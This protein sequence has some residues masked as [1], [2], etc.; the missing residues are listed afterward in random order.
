MVVLP[1]RPAAGGRHAPYDQIDNIARNSWNGQQHRREL[2]GTADA[3]A[4][5][6]HQPVRAN[7]R[8]EVAAQRGRALF[9]QA[10]GAV[11]DCHAGHLRH[12]GRR[13][14]GPRRKRK[15]VQTRKTA[16]VDEIERTREHVVGFGRKAG[17]HI[18]AEGD[19]RPQPPHLVAER[20]GLAAGMAP[21]HALQ[22]EIVA[23][24]QGQMQMRH[25]PRLIGDGVEQIG[26]SLD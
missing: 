9:A 26:V 2:L 21:L 13:R 4:F 3:A 22:N 1:R 17:D 6:Q 11:F 8:I 10:A 18:G 5:G 24:L 14:A 12:A 19:I 20:D 23:G 15:N 25:Q 7:L 16:F